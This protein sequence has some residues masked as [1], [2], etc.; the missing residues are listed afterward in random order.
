M[1]G[2]QS[3]FSRETESIRSLYI[4]RDVFQRTDMIVE[5]GKSNICSSD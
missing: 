1:G 2:Y 4:H 5:A 3:Q